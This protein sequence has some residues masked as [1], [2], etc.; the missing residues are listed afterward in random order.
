MGPGH[1][2]LSVREA[3]KSLGV[4]I[5]TVYQLLYDG[6]IAGRKDERGEWRIEA[7]SVERYR[8]RRTVR[9]TAT[10]TALRRRAIDVEASVSA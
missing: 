10:R 4:R 6:V 8:L 1:N 5:G 3:A 9:H 2:E 7:E